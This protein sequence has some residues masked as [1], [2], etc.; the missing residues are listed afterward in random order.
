VPY[1]ATEAEGSFGFRSLQ[2]K[3]ALLIVVG[4]AILIGTGVFLIMPSQR[5]YALAIRTA[6]YTFVVLDEE[7]KEPIPGATID[8]WDEPIQPTDRKKIAQVVADDKGVAKYV[9]E[10]QSVEEVIGIG[11]SHKLEGVRRHPAGVGTFVDR[12]WCTLDIAANGYVPLKYKS[13]GSFDYDD[14]GYDKEGKFHRLEVTFM[15]RRK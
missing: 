14:N 13:L 8:I 9:R 10:N 15:L 3:R 4:L 12:F 6:E 7:T 2:M 5:I 11:A 1:R